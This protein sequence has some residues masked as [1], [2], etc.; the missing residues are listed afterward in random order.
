MGG[1]GKS[2]AW[3]AALLSL[4]A[5]SS[6]LAT[7]PAKALNFNFSVSD[8]SNSVSGII[9]GLVDNTTPEPTL[10][11]VLSSTF[12]G[13]G[14]Y[15]PVGFGSGFQVVN[16]AIDTYPWV[17]TYSDPLNTYTLVFSGTPAVGDPDCSTPASRT[18]YLQKSNGSVPV[19]EVTG[20]DSIPFTPAPVPGPLPQPGAVAAFGCSRKL[21][22]RITAS[23]VPVA[24]VMP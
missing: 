20:D 14:V 22:E 24:L 19:G 6:L 5:F 12:G 13:E 21:R 1:D 4:A 18:V 15:T 10:V 2:F 7:Q 17:G 11:Q 9:K 16:G 8:S 23:K 3:C